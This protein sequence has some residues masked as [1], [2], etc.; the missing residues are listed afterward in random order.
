MQR[1]VKDL[2]HFYR[3]QPELWEL[4]NSPGGF[5]WLQC[6]DYN[7]SVLVFVRYPLG[8]ESVVLA[9]CNFTPVPRDGYRV[10]LPFDVD[11][12]WKLCLNSDHP[13]YGGSGYAIQEELVAQSVPFANSPISL[14]LT[15]PPMATV[16]YKAKMLLKPLG[17][18]PVSTA[19]EQPQPLQS[20]EG[21]EEYRVRFV[22]ELK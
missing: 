14:E 21:D 2:N 15:I 5:R 1:W 9:I 4:D 13:Q 12:S 17:E 22:H 7:N 20:E 16:F 18:H 19:V 8:R 3:Q 10:G 11:G 6:D